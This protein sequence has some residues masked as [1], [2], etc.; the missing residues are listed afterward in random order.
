MVLWNTLISL[1]SKVTP[2]IELHLVQTQPWHHSPHG[3]D[4]GSVGNTL[5]CEY[6]QGLKNWSE[7]KMDR[8]E[9]SARKEEK[10]FSN[11]NMTLNILPWFESKNSNAPCQG[12][13][14][15]LIEELSQDLFA[16]NALCLIWQ[17]LSNSATKKEKWSRSRCAKTIKTHASL[18][19]Q[20]LC[21][22]YWVNHLL[23]SISNS[24][25]VCNTTKTEEL[26]VAEYLCTAL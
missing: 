21:H 3:G 2:L 8:A 6:P 26:S 9:N 15:N 10:Q 25:P 12:P 17:S 11:I 23:K 16:N 1:P 22:N 24:G 19:L 7:L 13:N 5:L 18:F 4:I 20:A 14:S